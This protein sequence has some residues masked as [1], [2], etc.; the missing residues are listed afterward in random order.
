[1]AL[2]CSR[3][4]IS[5]TDAVALGAWRYCVGFVCLLPITLAV[6]G[7]WPPR[8]D[9]T[10]VALLGLLFFAIFPVLYNLS[11]AYTTA[12][13][14]SLA[15]STLPLL[16]MLAAAALGIETLTLRKSAGVVIAVAGVAA[17]LAAGLADAPAGAWRGDLLMVAGAF[18]MALY[19]VWSRPFIARSSPLA[20]L[21][22]GMGVGAACLA[23][24]ALA[25]GGLVPQ[26]F[27]APQWAA[28]LF[29]GVFGA[30][31]NFY[32][33]VWA[34]ERT[35]PTRVATTITVNPVSASLLAVL[36]LGEPI[37]LNLGL[38]IAAVL[39]GICIAAS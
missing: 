3:F 35:T 12:A 27:G 31:L 32:L 38:G 39:V 24:V 34:L 19:N 29:V 2:A 13:R 23:V 1:M 5:A 11:I 14:A 20:F 17:A 8:A 28:V 7:R 9:W 30:A 4:V 37:G 36:I 25:G 15:L 26:A 16:T 22:G 6:R 33:W 10:A 18:C 21:T